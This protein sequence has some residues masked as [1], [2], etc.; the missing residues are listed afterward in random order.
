[1][2]QDLS[3]HV[4]LVTFQDLLFTETWEVMYQEHDIKESS[5]TFSEHI[6]TLLFCIKKNCQRGTKYSRFRKYD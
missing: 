3:Q 4:Q 1:M 6:R 2:R 5:V